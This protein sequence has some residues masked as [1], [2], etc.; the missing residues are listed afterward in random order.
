VRESSIVGIEGSGGGFVG[1]GF[2]VTSRYILTCAHVVNA[3]LGGRTGEDAQSWPLSELKISFPYLMKPGSFLTAKVVYWKPA[4]YDVQK[5]PSANLG[6][7]E[8]IAGLEL[9]DLLPNIESVQLETAIAQA[10]F[11]IFG[12]PK[13]TP[14]GAGAEGKIRVPLPMGWCQLDGTCSEGLWAEP[15]YSGGAV[16]DHQT[17]AVYGMVVA[18]KLRDD[19]RKIAYMIPSQKLQPAIATLRLLEALLCHQVS[20]EDLSKIYRA[21]YQLCCPPDWH[22]GRPSPELLSAILHELQEMGDSDI[23]LAS[24]QRVSRSV[25]FAA[26]LAIYPNMPM[27]A[28]L[29]WL[30]AQ[31][32]EFGALEFGALI[33]RFRPTEADRKQQQLAE[34]CLIFVVSSEK[35]PYETEAFWL[36][37]ARSYDPE[38][39]QTYQK[40][41]CWDFEKEQETIA[42]LPGCSLA[43]LPDRLSGY[44]K[45]CVERD[46]PVECLERLEVLL[47]LALMHEPIE[48][49]SLTHN[50]Y[51]ETIPASE[52][53]VVVRCSE[54]ITSAYRKDCLAKWKINWD[55]LQSRLGAPSHTSMQEVAPSAKAQQLSA[56][57]TKAQSVVGFKLSNV[58][59]RQ[60]FEA[61]LGAAAPVAIW[62]RQAPRPAMGQTTGDCR[63]VLQW[64]DIFLLE[65][66]VGQLPC[67]ALGVRAEAIANLDEPDDDRFMLGH[68]LSLLWENPKLL[69]PLASKTISEQL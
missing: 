20:P 39:L 11:Q 31:S 36:P 15:G 61:L 69:P 40:V 23:V 29:Q 17:G 59:Q 30:Q 4:T 12:Y 56:H 1:C 38:N 5:L 18:A 46:L 60:F 33:E 2:A 50:R 37:D 13:K 19:G 53:Q 51:S 43:E 54:R 32:S 24:G 9:L 16:W 10:Q 67:H 63:S 8:D 35:A 68:H 66:Q 57:Y 55:R 62:L 22:L 6:I 52:F 42:D 45:T 44:F 34:P 48:L 58:P 3:A 28:L 25:E 41:D 21:A 7:E 27:D 65:C 64:L 47:P 49:W 26:R 14:Q